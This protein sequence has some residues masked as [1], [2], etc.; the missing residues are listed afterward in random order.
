VERISIGIDSLYPNGAVDTAQGSYDAQTIVYAGPASNLVPGD[1]NSSG[2]LFLYDRATGTTKL[3]TNA[4]DGSPS[5]GDSVAP[6]MTYDGRYVVFLSFA[7]NLVAGDN[8]GQPDIFVYDVDMDRIRRVSVAE[9]G[10][11][12]NGLSKDPS[13][14]TNGRFASFTTEATNLVQGDTNGIRDVI[15]HD[16]LTGKN[17]VASIN[18]SGEW[19]NAKA[20]RSYLVPDCR[21]ITIASD[22]T[23]L[24]ANDTNGFRDLFLGQIYYPAD[25]GYSSL[26]SQGISSPG[27]T[28]VYSYTVRNIGY[29]TGQATWVSVVPTNTTYLASSA[30]GGAVYNNIENQVEWQGSLPGDSETVFSY[31][32]I[33]D[34]NLVDPTLIINRSL[35]SHEE[36]DQMYERYTMVNGQPTYFPL[37]KLQ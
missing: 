29:E 32:V 15:L 37:V 36:W 2:D 8:N 7:S 35:L 4:P 21:A 9:D 25:F 34:A 16:L 5:N 10:T 11:E 33:V 12:S 26:Y 22:A 13:I 19:G 28:L 17:S 1:T 30:T 27:D 6:Q 3:F 18:E 14:C 31:A 24:V 23:N 20:H